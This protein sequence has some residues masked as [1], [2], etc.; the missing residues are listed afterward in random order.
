MEAVV[1]ERLTRQL[2][3]AA[4][5]PCLCGAHTLERLVE[6]G[7][8][9][10]GPL[11]VGGDAVEQ[12]EETSWSKQ[13][14]RRHG[15]RQVGADGVAERRFQGQQGYKGNYQGTQQQW[16]PN[17][18]Y[19]GQASYQG[20]Q[21]G[22]SQFGYHGNQ[23]H[24][25]RPTTEAPKGRSLEDLFQAIQNLN[26]KVDQVVAHNK[27]LENQIANQASPSRNKVIGKLPAYSENPKDQV[28]AITTR[29]GKQLQDPPLVLEKKLEEV[30]E[31]R[32]PEEKVLE[33]AQDLEGETLQ[34][35]NGNK[36]KEVEKYT[37]PLPFPQRLRR[38]N[39]DERKIK[40]FNLIKQLD[41]SIPL[42][43]VVTQI[44]SY[45]KFLKE[46]LS[47]RRK[48]EGQATIAMSEESSAIIQSKLPPKLKDPGS[49]SIPC[50]IGGA[51]V[52]RALCDLGASVSLIPYSLCKRLK[53]G[54]P[55]STSMTIQLAD[56]SVK[57]PVGILEDIP[58]KIDK[59]FIPGDFVVLEMEE[60]D[61][62][63]IILGRP[64]L[65]TAGAMID[66]KSGTL[67]IEVG[68][69]KVEFNIF[70]MAKNPSCADECFRM[71]II[72]DCVQEF[73]NKHVKDP[74]EKFIW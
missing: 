40:F 28:N 24:P 35:G 14:R 59:Y 7:N 17:Q 52:S 36:N 41:I 30:V 1:V 33:D 15:C 55:N 63:P 10:G 73:V 42:L 44:P 58:V 11:E 9:S 69:D 71:D 66:V 56:H 45:A 70:K 54:D 18:G 4:V 68:D 39:L 12:T 48:F 31:E 27:M 34:M 26:A 23:P 5:E 25:P 2:I 51:V 32:E 50:V 67:V 38:V 65:A 46:I 47:N 19:H 13:R 6:T 62:I 16:R 37:P 64:F 53:L 8:W 22:P 29:S 60:D 21:G 57:H 43:D 61:R 72:E 3:A 20:H 74:L 49:F